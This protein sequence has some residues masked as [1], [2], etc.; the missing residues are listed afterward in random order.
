MEIKYKTLEEKIRVMQHYLDGGV[1]IS[2][3]VL[4]QQSKDGDLSWDWYNLNYDIYEE[5]EVEET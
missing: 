4:L 1:I 3:G 5:S 2:H